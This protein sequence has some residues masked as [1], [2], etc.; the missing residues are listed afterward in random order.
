M[1]KL[2]EKWYYSK[3]NVKKKLKKY[4]EKNLLKYIPGKGRGNVSTIIFIKDFHS[5]INEIL[6]SCIENND[7][8]FALQL[9]QLSIPQEWFSPFLEK[10][11]TLF[12]SENE[13]GNNIIR[14][15][16]NRKIT[17]L[18]PNTICLQFEA[19][20]IKQISNTLVDYSEEGDIFTPSVA[21]NW[22]HNEEFTTWKF[23]IRKNIYFHD[24][25]KVTGSDILFS[26]NEALRSSTGK[27]LLNNLENMYCESEFT[28]HFNFKKPEPAFLKLVTHY[29]LVIR[30]AF[31]NSKYFIGCGPF[32]LVENKNN[33]VYLK[34]FSK[35]FKETPLIDGIEFWLINSNFKKWLIIPQKKNLNNTINPIGVPRSG[36]SYLIFNK[37]KKNSMDHFLTNTLKTIFNVSDFVSEMHNNK[38]LVAH[39]YFYKNS[40][41]KKKASVLLEKEIIKTVN[42]PNHSNKTLKLAVYNHP[43]LIRE[44]L[45]FKKKAG[46]YNINLEIITYSFNDDY[47][48]KKITFD[49][50]MALATDIPVTDIELGYFDFLLNKTLIFQ[51][52]V[53]KNHLSFIYSLTARYRQT[54]SLNHKVTL[55]NE[56]ENYINQENLL[57]YLYHPL[58]YYNI[59]SFINGVEFDSNGNIILNKLW[60]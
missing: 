31:S 26:F 34:S 3:Q 57:I 16:I 28:V 37:K 48:S 24:E 32:K 55:I 10:I 6:T 46:I 41:T 9:S 19:S 15:I 8:K 23:F 30:P 53:S 59:H 5:E 51:K 22:S 42:L 35:Y 2:A 18:D 25:K 47:F 54:Q 45:W 11:Q 14:F 21:L 17:A 50:D 27:W 49:A 43:R 60:W 38:V 29:S 39:S 1:E 58:K 44:A 20:L 56:I 4:E 12:S 13:Y 7:I 36:V 33:Y 40:E 52:F